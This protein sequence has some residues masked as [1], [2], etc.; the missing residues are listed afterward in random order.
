MNKKKK[1]EVLE[2]PKR[3]YQVAKELNI[4][5]GELL[6]YL[7]ERNYHVKNMS[8]MT[9]IDK[10]MYNEIKIRF[11]TLKEKKI[12]KKVLEIPITDKIEKI[13]YNNINNKFDFILNNYDLKEIII[14]DFIELNNLDI[15]KHPKSIII[16]CGSILEAL[17]IYSLESA[18]K[19]AIKKCKKS[20][21]N[22][23]IYEWSFFDIV[24]VSNEVG[25][26]RSQV[27]HFSKEIKNL[28]NFVHIYLQLKEF[29]KG[30]KISPNIANATKSYFFEAI[31]EIREWNLQQ[32]AKNHM[33]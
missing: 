6:D 33:N 5:S 24:K 20:N 10:K 2:R 12:T 19:E 29:K 25:I 8:I 14:K 7:K 26:I 4:E 30:Y 31:E 17:L 15:Y 28:R 22:E 11:K 3:V 13:N 16:L 32:I 23:P 21:K 18:E 1:I 9:K 27:E